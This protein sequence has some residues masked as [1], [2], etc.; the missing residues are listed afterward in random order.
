MK[1]VTYDAG[2]GPRAGVLVDEVIVDLNAASGGSLPP[3]MLML[4]NRP[5][6]LEEI[7]RLLSDPGRDWSVPERASVV[8]LGQ[9]R[10]RAPIPRPGKVL[11]LGLNYR[12][13]AVES[14]MELPAE[15]VVFCKA[16][17]SVIGPGDAIALPDVSRQVDYEVEL[18]FVMGRRAQRVNAAQAMDYVAG[19][20]VVNDVSA[21]DYQHKPPAHQWY[22]AK[23]FDTFCPT[24]PWIVTSDEI[25]DPH[26]LKL[27]CEVSGQ[28]LQC[29][30]TSWMVFRIPEIIE[31]LTR[32]HTLEPGDVVAT[33]TPAGVGAERTPPRFLHKG[34]VVRCTVE[35]IGTLENPVL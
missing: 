20:M 28:P 31:Y 7:H 34:D 27:T 32:V 19:Y 24:G 29:S 21:R 17:T 18:A 10:L 12:E 1:L 13:H 22:L 11:A 8:T 25:P 14:A 26:N 4:L 33:G 2:R 35:R 3:D 9:A 16:S 5:G 15:P 30:N 23:S 6:T